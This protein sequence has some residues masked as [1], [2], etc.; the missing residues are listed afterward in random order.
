VL[1]LDEVLDVFENWVLESGEELDREL[2]S[3]LNSKLDGEVEGLI[4]V[5]LPLKV[6]ELLLTLDSW[7]L[8]E[9]D[10]IVVDVGWFAEFIEVPKG[11]ELLEVEGV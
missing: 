9:V 11:E 7:G 10:K 3:E 2:N 8:E 5:E 4:N 1:R 6:G